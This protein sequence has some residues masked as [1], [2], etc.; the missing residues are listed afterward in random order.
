MDVS[1]LLFGIVYFSDG[2]DKSTLYEYDNGSPSTIYTLEKVYTPSI[3][4]IV[5]A[6]KF[7]NVY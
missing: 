1:I 6:S 2:P 4:I 3:G 5:T 7:T